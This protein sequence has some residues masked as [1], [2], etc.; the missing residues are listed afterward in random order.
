M[1][2][3][4][5]RY[6]YGILAVLVAF[7][8]ALL[9]RNFDL[10]GFLFVIAVAVSVWFGGRGPGLLAILLSVFLL[11]YFFLSPSD[12][13]EILPTHV[14][15][16]V[17]F[18]ILAVALS[19]LSEARHRAELSLVD[20]RDELERKVRERTAELRRSNE[21]LRDE[22]FVRTRAEEELRRS[23]AFLEEGQR[24]SH[25]GSWSWRVSDGR[26]HWS[27]ELYRLVGLDPETVEP[28]LERSFEAIHPEDRDRVR[29]AFEGALRDRSDY[30]VGCRFVLPDGTVR[31]VESVGHALLNE[32]RELVEIVGTTVDVTER[33]AAEAEIRKQSE[34]LGLAHDAII[35]RDQESRVLFWNPGAAATYGWTVEEAIGRVTHE[36]LRTTFPAPFEA[37]EAHLHE[38]GNWEGELSHVRRDGTPVVVA[39][40]WS[41]QRDERGAPLATLE[42]NRDVTDRKQAEEALRGAE[43][44]LAHV[45]RV[46]TLGEVSASFAHEVNQPLAAIVNNANACLGLLPDDRSDLDEVREALADIVADAQ[47]ASAVIDRVRGFAKRS[48]AEKAPVQLGHVVADVLA[49]AA[50]ESAARGV[51][52]STQLVDEMP[53]VSGD[54]VQLQQVLLNL[55][56]NA[57][58]AMSDVGDGGRI[59]V[60]R[61]WRDGE[62]GTAWATIAVEDCG[63]GLQGAPLGRLFE[64]FYTTKPQG[65]GLGLAISRTIIEAHG[66]KLWAEPN[67]G[68]GATFS[69]RLPAEGSTEGA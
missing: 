48:S 32:A 64:A 18:A 49:L 68:P 38:H 11:D 9:S 27:R 29:D 44:M 22:V 26:L 41:L 42:I 14:G 37:I 3:G 59:L 47:R 43:A 56:V 54:R 1:Q 66:G 15:Y 4:L 25:T 69:F 60:I 51:T 33:K 63:H 45:T 6:G 13:W 40:R 21:Q 46:A 52:I 39:S 24:L 65:M 20:A 31:D 5:R 50:N 57:M 8:A 28:S 7:G 35:V 10:E 30:S 12:E 62:N 58:D 16:F 17:V 53:L 67:P 36:L 2:G 61:G 34:L 19:M 23:E 55:V